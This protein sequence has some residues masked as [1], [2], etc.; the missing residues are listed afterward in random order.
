MSRITITI[1][2]E[3]I[4]ELM[5]VLEARSKTEAVINAIKNEIKYKKKEKIKN[6]AGKVDFTAEA[7]ELRHGDKR[8]G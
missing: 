1:P 2:N 4:N 3:L 5:E 7:Y 8:I 6:L